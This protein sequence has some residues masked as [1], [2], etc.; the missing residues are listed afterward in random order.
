MHKKTY[1]FASARENELIVFWASKPGNSDKEVSDWIAFIKRQGIKRVC[2]L[3]ADSQLNR[4]SDL[5]GKY[6][7]EFGSHCVCWTPIEDFHL[8]DL[9]T[10]TQKILPFLA[11]ADKKG[12]KVVVHCSGGIGR[13]GHLLAAW[14]VSF[15]GLSN[16]EAI[17]AVTQGKNP[18]KVVKALNELL[19]NCRLAFGG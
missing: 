18:F 4:Y 17:A 3:L 14:L 7:Q 16:Q 9:E 13:T 6:K 5:L 12:E 10:L 15:Q 8:C 2:C 11:Q 19:N 1:K